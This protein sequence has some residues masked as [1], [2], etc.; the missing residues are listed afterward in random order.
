MNKSELIQ[1]ISKKANLKV[2]HAE[3]GINSLI[4]TVANELKN[5]R[6]VTLVGFGTFKVADRASRTGVN[7]KT[8]ARITIKAKRVPKFSPGKALKEKV[9]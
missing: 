1:A 7:P 2:T 4:E 8:G 6:N 9:K 5:K 3:K